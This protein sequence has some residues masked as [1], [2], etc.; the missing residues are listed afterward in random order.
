MACGLPR[1]VSAERASCREQDSAPEVAALGELCATL[2]EPRLLYSLAELLCYGMCTGAVE[3]LLFAYVTNELGGPFRLCG[4]G[5]GMMVTLELPLFF[6]GESLLRLGRNTLFLA[7][8]ASYVLRTYLYTRLTPASVWWLLAIEPLHGFCFTL[9]NIA[10]VDYLNAAFPPAWRTTFQLL[11]DALYQ[12]AGQGLGSG[13][14]GALMHA[15]GG[16]YVYRLCALCAGGLLTVHVALCA[17]L[18]VCGSAP[19]LHAPQRPPAR[20]AAAPALTAAGVSASTQVRVEPLVA[21]AEDE[22]SAV[23]NDGSCASRAVRRAEQGCD[24][25]VLTGAAANKAVAAA[26]PIN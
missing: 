10:Y 21:T 9:F 23:A 11:L 3:K 22:T 26:H 1:Q 2:C 24:S 5:V 17:V 4:Y 13:L 7:A 15:R 20:P 6:Y 19:L 12:R 16:V 14:G 25:A 18:L 8:L